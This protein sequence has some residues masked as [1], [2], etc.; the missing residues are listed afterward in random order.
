MCCVALKSSDLT[1]R[2]PAIVVY[3]S[4][5]FN[6]DQWRRLGEQNE[7]ASKCVAAQESIVQAVS[8]V[9][10]GLDDEYNCW[11]T[12]GAPEVPSKYPVT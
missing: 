4:V 12:W 11:T 10:K 9:C 7:C 8:N 1:L 2:K 3:S 6:N 5:P